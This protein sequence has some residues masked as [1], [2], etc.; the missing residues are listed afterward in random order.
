MAA[1]AA[2]FRESMHAERCSRAAA[3]RTTRHD[4]LV[5]V[6]VGLLRQAGLMAKREKKVGLGNKRDDIRVADYNAHFD[7][8]VYNVD[9]VIEASAWPKL[10][11]RL[12]NEEPCAA[13]VPHVEKFLEEALTVALRAVTRAEEFKRKKYAGCKPEVEPLG[14]SAGGACLDRSWKRLRFEKTGLK[15][16][17]AA[18]ARAQVSVSVAL[19]KHLFYVTRAYYCQP[20]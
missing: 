15:V 9:G 14:F 19:L 17:T 12:R 10:A 2:N 13:T 7:V 18:R 6:L 4:E 8:C 5:R 16:D 20:A 3:Y 11:A 1:A